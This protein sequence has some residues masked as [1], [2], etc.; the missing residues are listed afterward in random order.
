MQENY[1]EFSRNF[2]SKGTSAILCTALFFT[3][4]T[5]M[6]RPV[7]AADQSADDLLKKPDT[8]SGPPSASTSFTIPQIMPATPQIPRT[9]Q[10]RAPLA[11]K[12][13]LTGDDQPSLLKDQLPYAKDSLSSGRD[14]LAPDRATL[15][16][17]K[18]SLASAKETVLS[19]LEKLITSD[20]TLQAGKVD[21]ADPAKT[22]TQFGYSFF[23]NVTFAPQTDLSVSDDYLTG[24][25]DSLVLNVWGSV[26]GTYELTVSRSGEVLLPR[27]GP[28]KVAGVPFGKLA[29][30]FR[31]R[32]NREFRDYH[33]S[34]NMGKL[35]TI[36]VYVVG[37]VNSPG[38]YSVS[39]LS[40]LI[41]ALGAAGGPT[42]N[43]SL[44]N[45]TLRR[46][47]GGEES[48]D[49]YSFF[50]RGDKSRDVR[51]SNGDTIFVPVV[52][53]VA[54]IAGSVKRPAIYELKAE[55][56]LKELLDL[57]GGPTATGYLQHV[58]ISRVVANQKK[59]VIDLNLDGAASGKTLEQLTASVAIQDMDIVRFF[60]I[61]NLLRDH[62]SLE[63]HLDRPGFYALKPGLRLSDVLKTEHFLPEYFP[64]FVE[65]TR[66]MPPELQPQKFVVNLDALLSLDPVQDLEIKEFDVIR[67]F[68]KIELER[69]P[70]V[71][72]AGEVF[73]PGEYRLFKDM[74]LRDLLIQAGYPTPSAYLASAEISRLTRTD[75]KVTSFPLSVDLARALQGDPKCNIVL[76][77]FDELTVRKI[78][79]WAAET[80]RH[81]TVSGE[82][83]FPGVYPIYKG[84]RLSSLIRR[85]GGYSNRAYL[86]G[87]KFSRESL[88]D[89]Q[90]RRMDE[91]LAR[92]QEA[93]TKKQADLAS[94]ASS[95][96]EADSDKTALEALQR[97]IN[98]LKN[99][100]AE[101][102][103]VLR[104]DSL[105]KLT[106]TRDDLELEG[107]DTLAVP[108]DPNAV[109]VLGMV[110]NPTSISFEP[111]ENAG[112]YLDKVGGPSKDADEDE[113]YLV[114]MDG[115]VFSKQQS[116]FLHRFNARP[117]D[118]GDTIIV[119]QRFE[120]TAWLRD[121]KDIA[122]IIGQAALAAGVMIAA[123]L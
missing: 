101:G 111:R 7:F 109:N 8:S 98:F 64:S 65:V 88:R 90:Q 105:E 12:I 116:S 89:L 31:L 80:E 44:R 67:V 39:S 43:G 26:E 68:S 57:A 62:F 16:A 97:N 78:P 85:A 9:E 10:L 114:K 18:D 81:V 100:R 2:G 106:G 87:A 110:Y 115:T 58:Q 24:P 70:K 36:K 6:V 93:V 56:S 86:A 95:K 4:I 3:L 83:R 45:I 42:K 19:P 59:K 108:S 96:E 27:G 99:K 25:G 15:P 69:Q 11:E 63:G 61:N 74:R 92:A 94:V 38:D 91:A 84:E 79:N 17:G 21:G 72:V 102:R 37:E 66:L 75:D 73:T 23:K 49:L 22:L 82:F 13:K 20:E 40:T 117:I 113:I 103:L 30:V 28:V 33:I 53:R 119:P 71:R 123:G 52:G 121:I 34:V 76:E 47:G 29:E 60:P 5:L 14:S 1:M 32:L 35:R 48:I 55:N 50:S 107:G 112:F 41:N 51:L 104:L 118:S 77:P 120:K 46:A 122:T 54:A